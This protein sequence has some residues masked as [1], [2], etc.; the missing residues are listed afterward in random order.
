MLDGSDIV[1]IA[2]LGS[3][4]VKTGPM[5]QTWILRTDMTPLDAS[6]AATDSSVCGDCPR[7]WATGGDCYVNLGQA[8]NST[9]KAWVRAG[10]PDANWQDKDV[11]PRLKAACQSNGLRMGSYGDPVAVP[12]E[13]WAMVIGMCKPRM[14]TGYTHQWRTLEASHQA[15]NRG[16]LDWFKEHIMASA[17]SVADAAVAKSLGWRYFAAVRPDDKPEGSIECLAERKKNPLTCEQCGI[18]NGTQGK[19]TRVSVYIVEHGRRS[20]SKHKRSRALQVLA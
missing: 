15:R 17:D 7:R 20:Q 2:T 11:Y 14:Y 8:P 5:V 3:A 6:K 10:K 19:A 1:C 13:L 9:Y 4:N 18:C 12:A 16:H